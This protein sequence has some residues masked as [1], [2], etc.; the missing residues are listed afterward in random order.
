MDGAIRVLIVDDS[1]VVRAML[2]DVF[3][4]D[5]GF[6]VVAEAATGREAVHLAC[7]HRPGLVTMDLEMP[8]MNG[9]DAIGEIMGSW[10]VP[11]LVVSDFADAKNAFAAISRGALD[12][13]A[14]PG[15]SDPEIEQFRDKARLV[16]SIRV[17]THMRSNRSPLPATGPAPAAPVRAPVAPNALGRPVVAIASSTGGPQA[18]AQILGSLGPDFD[19]PILIAQHVAPGF[20]AGMADWLSGVSRLPVRL[21]RHGEVVCPG[22]VYLSPSEAH[23][24]LTAGGCIAL[25]DI[26]ATD[27]YRPSCNALMDSVATVCGRRSIG[28]I[29]TGMGSDG[30][31]GMASIGQAGGVTL[32][33]DEASSVV[34]GMNRAAIDQG[35]VSKI[36]G[37]D[38]IAPELTRLA[39]GYR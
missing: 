13:V 17:I 19:C 20:A 5:V 8:E 37:L 24:T 32:A 38:N 26:G 15:I 28:L 7:I 3:E 9:I 33:Q 39:R 34:F 22:I 23:A 16:A 14:K 30:V 4:A 11:I 21:A 31:K 10:P 6:A 1:V 12:V 2:R 35:C 27:I 25:A 36:L 18:L 29:L